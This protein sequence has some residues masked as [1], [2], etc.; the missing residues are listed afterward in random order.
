MRQRKAGHDVVTMRHFG[1]WPLPTLS[2]F[3]SGVTVLAETSALRRQ[4][5]SPF[6]PKRMNR[7]QSMRAVKTTQMQA[8]NMQWPDVAASE[9]RLLPDCNCPCLPIHVFGIPRYPRTAPQMKV[10]RGRRH[11][12][13]WSCD[14]F[15]EGSPSSVSRMLCEGP[16]IQSSAQPD[17][18]PSLANQATS[19][20]TPLP[21]ASNSQGPA[22]RARQKPAMSS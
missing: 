8:P 16:T 10:T 17:I 9:V 14:G 21:K 15:S 13:P 12:R 20:Q 7:I 3:K 19:R 18:G 1:N 5:V 11:G 22:P 2:H 4:P 6:A